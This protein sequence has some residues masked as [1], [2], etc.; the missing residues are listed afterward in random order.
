MPTPTSTNPLVSPMC[1]ASRACFDDTKITADSLPSALK[2][3]VT[4]IA[5]SPLRQA[6]ETIRAAIDLLPLVPAS[7]QDFF[8]KNFSQYLQNIYK[9]DEAAKKFDDSEFIPKPLRL[10]PFLSVPSLADTEFFRESSKL[11]SNISV[12]TKPK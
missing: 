12:L 9:K 3:A 1:S 6:Y 10:K 7:K 4:S 11:K 5:K 8:A 2:N